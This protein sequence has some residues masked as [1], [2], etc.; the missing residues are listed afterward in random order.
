MFLLTSL[1]QL[2]YFN[3][4]RGIKK[5]L[6]I[7]LF[8]GILIMLIYL[9]LTFCR[10]EWQWYKSKAPFRLSS[11]LFSLLHT[12]H[13]RSSLLALTFISIRFFI[14]FLLNIP[15]SLFLQKIIRTHNYFPLLLYF[16]YYLFYYFLCYLSYYQFHGFKIFLSIT[17]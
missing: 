11:L 16:F 5:I 4:T 13:Y 8:W 14:S 6:F 1:W 17:E 15:S 3:K 9:L 12:L 2:R 10:V 7:W